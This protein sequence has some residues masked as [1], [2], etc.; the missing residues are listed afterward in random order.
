MLAENLW[1]MSWYVD[2]LESVG[3]WWEFKCNMIVSRI[4][5]RACR[6]VWVGRWR[7]DE[8]KRVMGWMV[9]LET[10]SFRWGLWKVR[11]FVMGALITRVLLDL[12]TKWRHIA[13]DRWPTVR[14]AL[15]LEW[16]EFVVREIWFA[17]VSYCYRQVSGLPTWP[18][19]VREADGCILCASVAVDWIFPQWSEFSVAPN[20]SLALSGSEFVSIVDAVSIDRT[21]STIRRR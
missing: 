4:D 11:W 14:L 20:E 16:V 2:H 15:F 5:L 6:C 17:R 18:W 19:F 8:D 12:H 3:S 1:W 9:M 10:C 13:I 7:D 21:Y